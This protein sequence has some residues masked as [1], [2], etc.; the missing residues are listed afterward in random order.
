MPIIPGRTLLWVLLLPL[1]L[2]LVTIFDRTYLMT[3]LLA[4]VGILVLA[5]VDV[6]LVLRSP[7]RIER[8]TPSTASLARS[9]TVE[10]TLRNDGRRPLQVQIQQD[11]PDDMTASDLPVELNVPGGQVGRTAYRI[12]AMRRGAHSLGDHFLRFPSP[13]GLWIRQQRIAAQ[14]LIRV[15]PDVQA[16]RHYELLARQNRDI[17]SSRIVRQRGGDTEFERLRDY[18]PEVKVLG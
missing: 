1:V 17:F 10:L 11:F 9:I 3:M 13:G 8:K 6:L 7:L 4:D 5:V 12:K 18:L 2:S 14:D 15:Y 16:V